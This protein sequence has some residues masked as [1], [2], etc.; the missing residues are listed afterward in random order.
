MNDN[1]EKLA[2][3]LDNSTW[4]YPLGNLTYEF[5]NGKDLWIKFNGISHY[6]YDVSFN[7]N[8]LSLSYSPNG[9]QYSVIC[10]TLKDDTTDNE[11][12]ENERKKIQ[13]FSK[14]KRAASHRSKPTQCSTFAFAPTH[15]PTLDTV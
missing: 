6:N 14:I 12:T 4:I 2:K 10:L 7:D 15:R 9:D 11:R 5:K 1:I 8:T 3:I 13:R